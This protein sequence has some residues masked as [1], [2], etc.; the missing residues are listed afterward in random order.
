MWWKLR[1]GYEPA[2]SFNNEISNRQLALLCDLAALE[3]AGM[4]EKT[5]IVYVE[6]D[7]NGNDIV[8][9]SVGVTSKGQSVIAN[10]RRSGKTIF[11]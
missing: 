4:I 1:N 8:E 7:Y 2:M 10:F 5:N 6:Q 3:E 9:L 11:P